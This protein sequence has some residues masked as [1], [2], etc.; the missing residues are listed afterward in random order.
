MGEPLVVSFTF[1]SLKTLSC[2]L[3]YLSLQGGAIRLVHSRRV[4]SSEVHLSGSGVP[5][6]S[7][8][9][10]V[11]EVRENGGVVK[12][13]SA[14]AANDEDDISWVVDGPLLVRVLRIFEGYGSLTVGLGCD[15]TS[16]VLYSQGSER[17]AKIGALHDLG[18]LLRVEHEGTV[19]HRVSDVEAFCHIVQFVAT[20]P[21]ATCAV[22]LRFD[23]L[24]S[25]VELRTSAATASA[26]VNGESLQRHFE[27]CARTAELSAFAEL[28]LRFIASATLFVGFGMENLAMFKLEWHS[29]PSEVS[30][31]F[32][33]FCTS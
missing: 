17:W 10:V 31:A 18:P 25:F 12:T 30:T 22:I 19:L 5:E 7:Y 9:E 16:V 23:N 21:D 11:V 4:G 2:C 14:D 24:Q 6:C 13:A 33:Y 15:L 8:S 29:V 28:A 26:L 32:L 20:S 3:K 27:G 1:P